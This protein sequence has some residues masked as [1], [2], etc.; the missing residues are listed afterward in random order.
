MLNTPHCGIAGNF[1]EE[2]NDGKKP[3]NVPGWFK[4]VEWVAFNIFWGG[5]SVGAGIVVYLIWA[6]FH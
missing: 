2:W 1:R 4:V 5:V 6:A 3:L